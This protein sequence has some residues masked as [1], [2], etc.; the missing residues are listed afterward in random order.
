MGL[1][2]GLAGPERLQGPKCQFSER[3]AASFSLGR[4]DQGSMIFC[5][6]EV[7]R[8]WTCVL[9]KSVDN[10]EFERAIAWRGDPPGTPPVTHFKPSGCLTI[11][12]R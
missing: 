4:V 11:I 1:N 10:Q 12:A 2:L 5:V 9:V 6:I 7:R 8:A 3:T